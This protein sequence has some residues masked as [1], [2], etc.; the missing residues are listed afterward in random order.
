MA[1]C[2]LILADNKRYWEILS[3]HLDGSII[4]ISMESKVTF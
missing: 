1:I 2:K 4:N 3:E